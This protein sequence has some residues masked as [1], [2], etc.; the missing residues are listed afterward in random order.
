M[1]I[2]HVTQ[3]YDGGVSRAM[4]NISKLLPD[5]NHYVIYSGSEDP[6]ESGGYS[7]I[8]KF[9]SNPFKR[10]REVRVFAKELG[11]EVIHAHSSWAGLYTRLLRLPVPVVYEPHC[12]VFDDPERHPLLRT[13]YRRIESFLSKRT[14][15]TVALTEHER[16]LANSIDEN[17]K[18]RILP[19]IP[20]IPTVLDRQPIVQEFPEITMIGRIA[21]QK[22]PAFFRDVARLSRDQGLPF[23]FVWIGAGS[24]EATNSLLDAGVEVTGWLSPSEISARLATTWMY[25]H[26][27]LYEGFPLSVLDAAA[28]GVPIIVRDL[29]CFNETRLAKIDGPSEAISALAMAYFDADFLESTKS[30]GQQLLLT[31]NEETHTDVLRSVYHEARFETIAPEPAELRV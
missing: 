1:K 21:P 24:E 8:K 12:F 9:S 11:A 29:P 17:A 26:S 28:A 3:C 10:I 19:N 25:F 6:T 22:D 2:L 5:I 20:T 13:A 31:M 7:G 23:K 15:I 18:V 4:D 16:E 14:S 30:G 27:A